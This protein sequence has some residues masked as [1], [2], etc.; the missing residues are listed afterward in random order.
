MNIEKKMRHI[1]I[2][3]APA[4]TKWMNTWRDKHPD[5]EYSVFTDKMLW[6]RKW[7]NQSLIEEYYRRRKWAGAHDLIR[8]ELI[9][10]QGGFLP[11]ADSVCLEN[12]DEL[13]TSPADHAYTV[14]ENEKAKPGYCSPILAA[15]PGNEVVGAIIDK[16]HTLKP[17]MLSDHPYMSTGNRFLSRFLPQFSDKTTIWPSYTLI[18]HWYGHVKR[19]DGPGKVY[20]EQYFGST[21][22]KLAI[23][24]YDQGR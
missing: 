24:G 16:L 6:A 2:G 12:T 8:Y 7:K 11:A 23:K 22:P 15:N 1:W 13:F 18:P 20:A 10:E 17:H 4:P 19:Y 21:G 9:Y 14:Y 5:W 3:P